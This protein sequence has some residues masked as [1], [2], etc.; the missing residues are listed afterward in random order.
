LLEVF[1]DLLPDFNCCVFHR[2][3]LAESCSVGWILNWPD[4]FCLTFRF[5]IA[6]SKSV[7]CWHVLFETK[8]EQGL[9]P[10]HIIIKTICFGQNE[11]IVVYLQETGGK[12]PWKKGKPQRTEEGLE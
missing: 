6:R 5:R 7:V 1:Q 11:T 8:T 4:I 2:A 12:A 9:A 10:L 3:Y